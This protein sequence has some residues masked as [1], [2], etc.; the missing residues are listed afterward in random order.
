MTFSYLV[1]FDIN[2]NNNN[3][4]YDNHDNHYKTL[5]YSFIAPKAKC[6]WGELKYWFSGITIKAV[7][8]TLT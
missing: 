7:G 2:N 3:N 6:K 1:S 8:A 5:V 4:N